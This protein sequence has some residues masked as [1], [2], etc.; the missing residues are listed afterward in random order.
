M[1]Q[2][3]RP[4]QGDIDADRL[5]AMIADMNESDYEIVDVRQDREYRQGHIPGA[6]HIPLAELE[7]R[8]EELEPERTRIFY[9]R[10]GSRS[11]MALRLAAESGRFNGPLYNLEQGILG[12]NGAAVPDIP[13]LELLPEEEPLADK[14]MRAM[15]LERGA[16]NMYQDILD[17]AT[18]PILCELMHKVIPMEENHAR[19]VYRH[20]QNHWDKDEPLKNFEHLYASLRGDILEGGKTMDELGPWLEDAKQGGC[21]PLAELALELEFASYDL[22]RSVAHKTE[23]PEEQRIFEALAG[24]EKDHAR[25]F[26]QH[27]DDFMEPFQA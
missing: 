17:A 27:V 13:R 19:A 8:L 10:S 1:N 15:N 23:D 5:R 24:Q 6:L 11:A 2:T 12:W 9:C 3:Q 16:Q 22:Y 7:S 4:V 25:L 21:A 20:L 14:L 18:S 26:M